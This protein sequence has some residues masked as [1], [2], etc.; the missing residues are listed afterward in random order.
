M[1]I[2]CGFECPTVQHV[3]GGI[4]AYFSNLLDR[5]RDSSG[6]WP[7]NLLSCVLEIACLCCWM[8][9]MV[10]LLMLTLILRLISLDV[11]GMM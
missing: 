6:K 7:C 11:A 4:S 9:R 10:L 1:D 3:R 5:C 2:M 8:H